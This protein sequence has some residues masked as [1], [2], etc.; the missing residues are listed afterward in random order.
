MNL[1][2]GI[3]PP[4][5]RETVPC[6]APTLWA[7]SDWFNPRAF[8]SAE[9]QAAK[10]ALFLPACC[11]LIRVSEL[12]RYAIWHYPYAMEKTSGRLSGVPIKKVLDAQGRRQDWLANQLSVSPATVN[13]WIRGNR[14]LDVRTGER[15]AAVLGV[16]FVLLWNMP[17]GID[18]MPGQHV[19]EAIPA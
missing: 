12:D 19:Q 10:E 9:S 11:L 5:H 18:S 4:I 1:G 6:E 17:N 14:T 7:N 16:P 15:V 8:S 2:S 13:R 3:R